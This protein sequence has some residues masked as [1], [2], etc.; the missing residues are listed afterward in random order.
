[1]KGESIHACMHMCV[2][3]FMHDVQTT[4]CTCV[5]VYSA[6]RRDFVV[7][8]V[9]N[10]I[11]PPGK[12]R[13]ASNAMCKWLEMCYCRMWH[14]RFLFTLLHHCLSMSWRYCMSDGPGSDRACT[15]CG[16]RYCAAC[17][18]GEHG[19]MRSVSKCNRCGQRPS[20]RTTRCVRPPPSP[21]AFIKSD[22]TCG[23]LWCQQRPHDCKRDTRSQGNVGTLP[24]T[25][26]AANLRPGTAF[27]RS[28]SAHKW[29]TVQVHAQ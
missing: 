28:E 13:T 15:T 6:R 14:R 20:A 5:Y 23:A 12:G 7:R 22:L 29:T 9:T 8:P 1:M 21:P 3:L 10:W 19:E 4:N 24:V 2:C 17:W 16:A 25:N 18:H 11:S 26:R 27:M